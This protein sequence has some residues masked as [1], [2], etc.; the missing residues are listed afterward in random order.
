MTMTD[1]VIS[2]A[3]LALMLAFFAIIMWKVR[4]L[5]LGIVLFLVGAMIVYDFFFRR[6]RAR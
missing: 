1:R 5:D 6:A 3:A 4:A 2:L